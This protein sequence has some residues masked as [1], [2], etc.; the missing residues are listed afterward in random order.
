MIDHKANWRSIDYILFSSLQRIVYLPVV[1]SS[2]ISYKSLLFAAV[3]E[4][5]INK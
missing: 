3:K 4:S 1:T 2:K 5:Q